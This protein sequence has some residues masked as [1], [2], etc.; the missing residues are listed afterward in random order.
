MLALDKF[1]SCPSPFPT[2]QK[3]RI[4]DDTIYS[5][6][7]ATLTWLPTSTAGLSR[8]EPVKGPG[9]KLRETGSGLGFCWVSRLSED[10]SQQAGRRG[11][12]M[13]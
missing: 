5:R 13:C 3:K 8:H 2:F 7:S 4:S 9:V 6:L 1:S 12:Q 11:Q 10:G